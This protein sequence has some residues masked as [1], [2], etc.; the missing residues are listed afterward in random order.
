MQ[1]LKKER[2]FYI[3]RRQQA[4]A[5]RAILFAKTMVLSVCTLERYLFWSVG[6]IYC[7]SLL[8]PLDLFHKFLKEVLTVD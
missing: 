6:I 3:D 8:I 2:V 7:Y 4:A 1:L 5:G